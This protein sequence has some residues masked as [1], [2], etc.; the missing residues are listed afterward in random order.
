MGATPEYGYRYPE[1]TDLLGNIAAATRLLAEDIEAGH[2]WFTSSPTDAPAQAVGVGSTQWTSKLGGVQH[3]GEFTEADGIVTYTG[4]RPRWFLATAQAMFVGSLDPEDI[5]AGHDS[6]IFEA[7][8]VRGDG[9]VPAVARE[10]RQIIN[11]QGVQ[12]SQVGPHITHTL[13]GLV[14]LAPG[15]TIRLDLGTQLGGLPGGIDAAALSLVGV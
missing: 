10:V 5:T 8:L 3:S 13:A 6:V 2:V 15:D 12:L 9:A 1:P 11:A 14:R 7:T 4:T